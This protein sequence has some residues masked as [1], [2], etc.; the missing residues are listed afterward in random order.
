MSGELKFGMFVVFCVVL[1]IAA[2]G[3]RGAGYSDG[4]QRALEECAVGF[5]SCE[6]I[7]AKAKAGEPQ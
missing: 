1:V 2:L 4:Y 5:I 3:M 6:P 7:R